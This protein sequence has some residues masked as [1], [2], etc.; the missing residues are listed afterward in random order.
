[1]LVGWLCCGGGQCSDNFG[2]DEKLI[3]M[4]NMIVIMVFIKEKREETQLRWKMGAVTC[5][6]GGCA[7]REDSDVITC[8]SVIVTMRS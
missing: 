6:M 5:Q 1:M 8:I 7:V 3:M 4:M 2:H